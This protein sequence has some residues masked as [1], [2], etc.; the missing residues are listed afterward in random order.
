MQ[1][2]ETNADYVEY[3]CFKLFFAMNS[4]YFE[5][6]LYKNEKVDGTTKINLDD[7]DCDTFEF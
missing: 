2:I 4:K 3:P 7:L 6:I 5:T 1:D